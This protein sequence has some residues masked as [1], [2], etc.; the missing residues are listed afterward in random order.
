MYNLDNIKLKKI[1]ESLI[2]SSPTPVSTK[3]LMKFFSDEEVSLKLVQ[4]LIA[5][6]QNQYS[7]LGV[8]L[9]K[10][11]IDFKFQKTATNGLQIFILRSLKNI[12]EL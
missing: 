2:F 7:N 4:E 8:N 6:L 3:E 5:E 12:Q 10:V 1:I 11:S 9:K